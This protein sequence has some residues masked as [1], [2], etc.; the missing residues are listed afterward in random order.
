MSHNYDEDHE[1]KQ[2]ALTW[3]Y[4][5]LLKGMG[6]ISFGAVLI[7]SAFIKESKVGPLFIGVGSVLGAY[8]FSEG[9]V[10]IKTLK[11]L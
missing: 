4:N 9:W 2:V 1:M 6:L 11:R 3:A 5:K 8:G 10:G 7:G